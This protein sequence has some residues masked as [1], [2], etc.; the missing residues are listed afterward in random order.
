[1]E[2][3]HLSYTNKKEEKEDSLYTKIINNMKQNNN[4]SIHSKIIKEKKDNK[5]IFMTINENNID[6]CQFIRKN[7]RNNLENKDII[8]QLKDCK[9]I[10]ITDKYYFLINNFKVLE[11]KQCE[12]GKTYIY[13]SIKYLNTDLNLF[14][15][16]LKA[17]EVKDLLNVTKFI[18]QD[19]YGNSIKILSDENI[20]FE[21]GQLYLFN[22][23]SY[24]K[25]EKILKS[26]M[27]SSIQ[28]YKNDENKLNSLKE[29]SKMENGRLV[30]FKCKIESFKLTEQ[31]VTI[32]DSDK[33]IYKVKINYTLLKEI[34]LN[35]ICYF[36]YFLKEN[37][38]EFD[39]T[40]FSDIKSKEETSIEFNFEDFGQKDNFYNRISINKK[41]YN[42]DQKTKDIK[43]KDKNKNNIF[44]QDIYYERI[45]KEREE[46]ICSFKF[47]LE[48]EKGKKNHFD[49]L[50]IS[51][52]SNS[53]QFYF[54][55][56]DKED[57]PKS[58][59]IYANGTNYKFTNPDK[60]G[61]ELIERFTIINIP[62]QNVNELLNLP[63]KIIHEQFKKIITCDWKY[64]IFIDDKH[65]K[66][67]KLFKKMKFNH[68]KGYVKIKEN[69]FQIIKKIF[70]ENIN[71][72]DNEFDMKANVLFPLLKNIG[73]NDIKSMLNIFNEGF[74]KYKFKNKRH[75]YEIIKYLSFIALCFNSIFLGVSTILLE[76]INNF[77]EILSSLVNLKY[78]DR[79]KVLLAFI[80]NFLNNIKQEN[81]KTY[82]IPDHII[83]FDLDNKINYSKYPYIKWAY[84]TLYEIIDNI[85]EECPLYQGISQLN[86]IIYKEIIT[87]KKFHSSSLLNVDDI[88]LE[89]IKNLN[90]FLLLSFKEGFYEDD[91]AE[92]QE[93]SKTTIIYLLSIFKERNDIDNKK[94][95]KIAASV[96]LIH[97]IHENLGHKKKDINNEKSLTP[98]THNDNNFK[99]FSLE[100]A[101][102]GDAIE[103]L[104]I[105][106]TFD[107]ELLMLNNDTEKLLD[108][109]L[110]ISNNF[111]ELR[112]IYN[113]IINKKEERKN[114][115]INKVKEL[116]NN[117]D[118]EEEEEEYIE[119]KE[120]NEEEENIEEE[121]EDENNIYINNKNQNE[122]N[123]E[124]EKEIYEQDT[125]SINE[126]INKIIV[127]DQCENNNTFNNLFQKKKRYNKKNIIDNPSPPKQKRLLFRQMKRI[128]GKMTKK[129]KKELEITNDEN[130]KRYLEIKKK[131]TKY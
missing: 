76:Y 118:I 127:E 30:N 38:N 66:D 81:K 80:L 91:S 2:N 101:D 93:E 68:K 10:V 102:S 112:K 100:E 55:V 130:Y 71:K 28:K 7:D 63:K 11:H 109:N 97:L 20:E 67:Y 120:E 65:K 64:L 14:S 129:E 57:L 61:N 21:N 88:R 17:K 52:G 123:Y 9:L 32:S 41:H 6:Y 35:G 117:E 60:F 19:V 108:S 122:I 94:Y 106:D 43:I 56:K 114:E 50:L 104:L 105:E 124:E 47:S 86:S 26:T 85:K 42:I 70:S 33:K 46:P 125:F 99:S 15:I 89:L 90:R 44:I 96:I 98:R 119:D 31:F 3:F 48:I 5:Y 107:I 121:E 27:I 92:Y 69:E 4:I 103:Y 110:Y 83:L 36:Y 25:S 113:G 116:E 1:M 62:K 23:Y 115:T 40:N 77:K 95:F 72:I 39:A 53:Y 87:N 75:D 37:N 29:I 18:F 73:K 59:I 16:I 82:L 22:G 111:E 126:E 78:I 128:Y 45:E 84:D 49:S 74:K 51:N 34:S 54:Q 58:I 131:K 8:F 13:N 24:N 12:F 79:I